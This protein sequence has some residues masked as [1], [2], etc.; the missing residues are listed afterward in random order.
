MKKQI[1]AIITSALILANITACGASTGDPSER[2]EI[3]ET[4]SS[5]SEESSSITESGESSVSTTVE[6]ETPVETP[7]FLVGPAGDPIYPSDITYAEITG[8][9]IEIITDYSKLTEDNLLTALCGN[10]GYLREPKGIR[11]NRYESP[12]KFE[13]EFP[14]NYIGEEILNDNPIK[15]VYVGEEICG[16]TVSK[17]ETAFIGNRRDASV[18]FWYNS[19][20]VSFKGEKTLTGYLSVESLEPDYPGTE[21]WVTFRLDEQSDPLPITDF[22][23][24]E[25][26]VSSGNYDANGFYEDISIISLGSIYDSGIVPPSCD[27]TLLDGITY[28]DKDVHVKITIDDYS[29]AGDARAGTAFFSTNSA[30]L[31][32]LERL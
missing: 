22:W 14:Y 21:G 6:S 23:N 8:S 26:G 13:S 2:S 11:Y 29:G 4:I 16:M 20:T 27:E 1:T 3:S 9:E 19:V 25:K 31:K 18:P 28:G 15:R 17:I 12:E 32:S 5:G 30:V 10:F 7:T 24:N